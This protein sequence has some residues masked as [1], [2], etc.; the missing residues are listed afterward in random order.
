MD[1]FETADALGGWV[2]LPAPQLFDV[3]YWDLEQAKLRRAGQ[4]PVLAGSGLPVRA[5]VGRLSLRE[6]LRFGG[7]E[8]DALQPWIA[9]EA[10][11]DPDLAAEVAEDAARRYPD[12]DL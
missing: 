10:L 6:W 2:A 7:V 9:T 1:I 12:T 4:P 3:E 5:D 8:L 11:V